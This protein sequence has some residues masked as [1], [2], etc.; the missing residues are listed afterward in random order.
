MSTLVVVTDDDWR[1]NE[2]FTSGAELSW[3]VDS[4]QNLIIKEQVEPGEFVILAE[5]RSYHWK[6]VSHVDED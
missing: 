6:S 4:N 1:A 2:K 5:F 3:F